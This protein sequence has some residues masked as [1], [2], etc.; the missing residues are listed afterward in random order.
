MLTEEAALW[1]SGLRSSGAGDAEG[2]VLQ[3]LYDR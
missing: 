1:L 2:L 3:P